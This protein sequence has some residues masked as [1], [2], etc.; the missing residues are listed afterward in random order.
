M[1]A[2]NFD[3]QKAQEAM[4]ALGATAALIRARTERRAQLAGQ[5]KSWKGPH[6]DTFWKKSYP[7]M[8]SEAGHV[9]QLLNS[10]WSAINQASINAGVD[11]G[12]IR[13]GGE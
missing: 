3:R 7:A 8:N 1:S 11:A 13:H 2:P 6:A 4:Q 5:M 9:I 12:Q 10:L